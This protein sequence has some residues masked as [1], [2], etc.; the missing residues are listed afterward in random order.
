[1]QAVIVLIILWSLYFVLHSVMASLHVKQYVASRWP[2]LMPWYRL[3]FNTVATLALAPP[4]Y[5]MYRYPG[6]MLWVWQGV[7]FYVANGLALA[8]MAGFLWSLRYYDGSEFLGLTQLRKHTHAIEDLESFQLSPLHR[9]VRHPWY[10]LAFV[11]IWTRDMNPAFLVSAVMLSLYFILGSRLE[12]KKLLRYH[13]DVYRAYRQKVPA[14]VPLPWR[15]L[16]RAEADRLL[17]QNSPL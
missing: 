6:E 4:L 1:M 11:L 15:Y 12:E 5:V 10:A 17:K 3:I 13:G 14:L 7:W 2:G 9:F 16:G 8:A